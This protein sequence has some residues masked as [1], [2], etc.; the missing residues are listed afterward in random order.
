LRDGALFGAL[1]STSGLLSACGGGES[2]TGQ[3][4]VTTTVP[5]DTRVAG[6]ITVATMPGPRW[7]SALRASAAAYK[8]VNPEATVNISVSAFDEHYQKLANELATD[9]DATDLWVF[10]VALVGQSQAKLYPLTDLYES[11]KEWKD[12]YLG[13]VPEV[14]RECW[15]WKGTPLA[16]VHDANAMMSWWRKDVLA[17]QG[18]DE[19]KT[20]E[21]MLANA[22][23]LSAQKPGSGFMTTAAAGPYL[24]VL[25]TG[26]MYAFGGKWWENDRPESFGRVS[27][28]DKPGQILLDSPECV[29]AMTMLR[30]LVKAGNAGS[31]NAKEFENNA[32]F[33]NDLVHQQLIYSGLM[34]LQSKKENPKYWD[35][36]VS[37]G[38]PVGGSNTDPQATGVK[39]GY[40][41]AI[42]KASKSVDLAFDFAKFYTSRE[43]A[44]TLIGAGGQPANATLLK[45][46]SKKPGYQAF[47]TIADMI[48]AG[49]HQA[50]FPEG[51]DFY[52]AMSNATASVLTGKTTPEQGCADMRAK[53]EKI[54]KRAG[55]V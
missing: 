4:D 10:D 22:K 47:G 19:P 20:F 24:A 7:E 50:Q 44:E 42:P 51:G 36:M 54:M 32:A 18:L 21:T 48:V 25:F 34:Q 33:N 39:A 5:T 46:W 53:T 31:L 3:D 15:S 16:V 9:S 17:Q 30:D 2:A 8:K 14:Y 41:L 11:D 13:G 28:D 52:D 35:Q 29:A 26:M 55:Y 38:F 6:T 1:A 49:H 43:N 12:W 23:T 40:G 37:A 27:G 45:E